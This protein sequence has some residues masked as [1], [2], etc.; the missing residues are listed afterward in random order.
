MIDRTPLAGVEKPQPHD[1][2]VIVSPEE[3]RSVIGLVKGGF[4]DL[5]AMAWESGIRPQ[6]IRVVE[7][8]HLIFR[9]AGSSS[10]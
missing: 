8:K 4:R 9:T 1:R 7:A 5:L 6:E 2:D 3:Y 10:R